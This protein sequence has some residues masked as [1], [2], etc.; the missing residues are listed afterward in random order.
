MNACKLGHTI[1]GFSFD[2]YVAPIHPDRPF[3]PTRASIVLFPE[4]YA[5][6]YSLESRIAA[7]FSKCFS[8]KGD[9]VAGITIWNVSYKGGAE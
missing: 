8:I 2:K 7:C 9:K 5:E 1:P 4:A 3:K 6:L